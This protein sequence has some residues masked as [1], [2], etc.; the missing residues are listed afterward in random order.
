ML[1]KFDQLLCIAKSIKRGED[2]TPY[3][4]YIKNPY[5]RVFNY[6]QNTLMQYEEELTVNECNIIVSALKVLYEY[7][8][9]KDKEFKETVKF[10]YE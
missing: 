3:D 1:R 5:L 2:F 7:F 6:W 8:N 4:D 9:E 10:Y